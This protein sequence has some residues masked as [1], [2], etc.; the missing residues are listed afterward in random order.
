MRNSSDL[1]LCRH[2]QC[3][4]CLR[5]H[6]HGQSQVLKTRRHYRRVVKRLIKQNKFD[7]VPT[8]VSVGH[9]A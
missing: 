5:H 1:K 8:K 3:M 4:Y 9:L 6:K 2:P 7:E